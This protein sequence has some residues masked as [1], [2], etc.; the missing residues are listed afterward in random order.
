MFGINIA[1]KGAAVSSVSVAPFIYGRNRC[2]R[3][4]NLNLWTMS[5]I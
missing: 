2:N 1:F 5:S 3:R 4:R